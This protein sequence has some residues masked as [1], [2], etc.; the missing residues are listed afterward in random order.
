MADKLQWLG[1]AYYYQD[2]ILSQFSNWIMHRIRLMET[3]L[4]IY[5]VQSGRKVW[6]DKETGE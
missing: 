4:L 2:P 6:I 1:L 5:H 3:G